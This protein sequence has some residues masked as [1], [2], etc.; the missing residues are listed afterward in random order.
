MAPASQ[1]APP[2]AEEPEIRKNTQS[3]SEFLAAGRQITWSHFFEPPP[4]CFCVE[5]QRHS[6]HPRASLVWE[7]L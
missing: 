2:E 6:E 4:G 5:L 3:L 1:A 7:F